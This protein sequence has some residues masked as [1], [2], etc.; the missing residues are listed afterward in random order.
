MG[1]LTGN[2]QVV[3][4]VVNKGDVTNN[5]KLFKFTFDKSRVYKFCVLTIYC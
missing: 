3:A 5:C 1:E 2:R 4:A